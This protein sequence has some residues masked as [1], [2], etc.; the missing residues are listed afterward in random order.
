MQ[1]K[2]KKNSRVSDTWVLRSGGHQL[3]TAVLVELCSLLIRTC[4]LTVTKM[5]VEK[6]LLI[7]WRF[8]FQTGYCDR[9][10]VVSHN[11]LVNVVCKSLNMHSYHHHIN[12]SHRGEVRLLLSQPE[13]KKTNIRETGTHAESAKRAASHAEQTLWQAGGY[14][15]SS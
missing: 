12:N 13:S 11:M 9:K 15:Y 6:S 14:F 8:L 7:E 1:K 4:F 3:P 10:Y 2:K 5:M